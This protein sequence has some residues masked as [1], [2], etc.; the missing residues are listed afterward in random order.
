LSFKAKKYPNPIIEQARLV[1]IQ[2]WL[3]EDMRKYEEKKASHMDD[4]QSEVGIRPYIKD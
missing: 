4:L 3:N 2:N 1:A